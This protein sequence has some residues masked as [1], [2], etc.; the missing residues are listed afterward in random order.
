[1][2]KKCRW[3]FYSQCMY[4]LNRNQHSI[5]AHRYVGA[6]ASPASVPVRRI[7]LILAVFYRR[8]VVLATP[9]QY[10]ISV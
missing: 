9:S 2:N 1:M 3:F 4:A 5:Y 8:V 6:H 7:G 10:S